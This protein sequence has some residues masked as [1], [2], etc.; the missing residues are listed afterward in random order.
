MRLSWLLL[1]GGYLKTAARI[2]CVTLRSHVRTLPHHYYY[3][4]YTYSTTH[5]PQSHPL[6][7][8]FRLESPSRVGPFSQGDFTVRPART[9]I[10][11]GIG[12][13]AESVQSSGKSRSKANSGDE[14]VIGPGQVLVVPLELVP[15]TQTQTQ[16][17]SNSDMG[18]G[19]VPVFLPCKEDSSLYGFTLVVQVSLCLCLNLSLRLMGLYLYTVRVLFHVEWCIDSSDIRLSYSITS[20]A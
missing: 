1:R 3:Y 2:V 7:L 19:D 10:G 4:Y 5:V 8:Q 13:G 15:P 14:V 9:G 16:Q 20:L 17:G 11:I 18:G 12:R 6:S